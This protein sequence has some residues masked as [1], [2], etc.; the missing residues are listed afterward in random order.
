MTTATAQPANKV[1][2][3]VEAGVDLHGE[4]ITWNVQGMKIPHSRLVEALEHCGIETRFV[5]E[6]VP[7]NAFLRAARKLA[8]DRII[9]RLDEDEAKIRFQ[10]TAE[11]RASD[12][13]QYERETIL[14]LS[15]S[16]GSITCDHAGLLALARAEFD[17]AFGTRTPSDVSSVINRIFASQAD[18]FSIKQTAGVFFVP[19]SHA[20]VVD[21]VECFVTRLG[22]TVSRFPVPKGTA[23]GDASVKASVSNGLQEMIWAHEEAIAEFSVSTRSDT[24]ERTAQRIQVTQ[25]KLLSYA[26]YLGAEKE[27]LE[28]LV[29]DAKERLRRRVI[30]ITAE[31]QAEEAAAAK[32]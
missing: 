22:G 29:T 31:K 5:R 26:E 27:R 18:I 25:H 21:R 24:F 16:D 20:Q 3:Q 19:Q 11:H 12:G 32:G 9:R 1:P 6:M 13:F 17:A 8:N 4:I 10:F 15:K 28:G 7:K 14:T 23:Q 2:F 30:E